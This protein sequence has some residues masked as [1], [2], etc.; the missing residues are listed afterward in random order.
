MD[1]SRDNLPTEPPTPPT[2][3]SEALKANLQ[4]VNQHL[5][6]LK[7]QWE[8]EKNKLLGEKAALENATNRLNG[9]VKNTQ[10]ESRKAKES[11]RAGERLRANVEHVCLLSLSSFPRFI[12][13]MFRS[14]RRRSELSPFLKLSWRLSVHV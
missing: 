2:K 12:D 10:E 4:A 6:E 11:N 8:S 9:Q 13:C 7:K 1:I 3:T 14:S 5:E